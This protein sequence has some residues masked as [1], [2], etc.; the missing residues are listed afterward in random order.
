MKKISKILMML[1]LIGALGAG[2]VLVRR[3]QET[4]RGATAAETSTSIL[5]SEI[6]V[7]PG[8]DFKVNLL[9]NTGK[10]TDKLTGVEMTVSYDAAKLK[11]DSITVDA[12]SGYSLL[13]DVATIDDGAG[14]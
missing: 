12:T 8:G 9:V 10:D 1:L 3:N 2:M 13:N 5:P 14:N 6:S 4:R 11:Y 7:Q